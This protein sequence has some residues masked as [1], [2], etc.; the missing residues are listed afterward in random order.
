MTPRDIRRA[1]EDVVIS[2]CGICGA[3][4]IDSGQLLQCKANPAH[5]ADKTTGLWDG[6][7]FPT[8]PK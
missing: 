5:F 8:E 2:E 6:H 7:T 3:G 1:A 4:A